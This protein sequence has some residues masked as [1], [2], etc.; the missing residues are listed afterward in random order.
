MSKTKVIP[1]S[2]VITN[3][4]LTCYNTI[5]A[6]LVA[7]GGDLS[8]RSLE[9]PAKLVM[10]AYLNE[11]LLPRSK[12]SSPWIT[13]QGTLLITRGIDNP[14][15][16]D[17]KSFDKEEVS[18]VAVGFIDLQGDFSFWVASKEQILDNRHTRIKDN[19]M[20]RVSRP[21]FLTYATRIL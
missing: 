8:A 6:Q 2:T 17:N 5:K 16:L 9:E 19:R 15:A 4:F 11:S 21:A 10:S 3:R 1:F 7:M 18:G 12:V 14:S 13:E 20:I